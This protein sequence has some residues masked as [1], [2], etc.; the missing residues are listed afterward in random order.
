MYITHIYITHMYVTYM[1][2]TY[3]YV[4]YTYHI[5]TYPHTHNSS[6]VIKPMRHVNTITYTSHP[7]TSHP[8]TSH[9]Y[10]IH[11][12]PHT[13]NSSYVIKPMCNSNTPGIHITHTSHP[14][15]SHIHHI[16]I[17]SHIHESSCVHGRFMAHIPPVHIN[18]VTMRPLNRS[19]AYWTWFKGP[20]FGNHV[21]NG[22]ARV[23]HPRTSTV[24]YF[25]PWIETW[26]WFVEW[27]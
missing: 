2:V 16:H 14:C 12:Y 25:G 3:M 15:A 7:C 18:S 8:C 19:C 20:K 23:D 1:Y 13:H 4:T 6:Y 5:Y 21:Q 24:L 17:Y 9:T 10:H 11:T 26:I 22:C 27:P